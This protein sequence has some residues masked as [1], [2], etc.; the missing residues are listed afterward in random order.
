MLKWLSLLTGALLG[1]PASL[2]FAAACS[3][4]DLSSANY[5]NL[6]QGMTFSQASALLPCDST[7]LPDEVQSFGVTTQHY[8]WN[9]PNRSIG[10][11]FRLGTLFTKNRGGLASDVATYSS[12]DSTLTMPKV[13]VDGTTFTNARMHLPFGG[14]WS[15]LGASNGVAAPAD[16]A[17]SVFNAAA[18]TLMVPSVLIDG[19]SFS[20]V[21]LHLLSGSW[22]VLGVGSLTQPPLPEPPEAG[23]PSITLAL[24]DIASGQTVSTISSGSSARLTATIR[25]GNGAPIPGVVVSFATD[26]AYGAFSPATGTALSDANGLA[27]VILNASGATSGATTVTV[28]TQISGVTVTSSLN[29]AIGAANT[30]DTGSI[31]FVSVSPTSIGLRGTGGSGRQESATVIFRVVDNNNNPVGGKTVSFS[32]STTLGGLTLSAATAVSDP[33]SGQVFTNVIAGNMSTAVRVTATVDGFSTQSD[34][35]TISTGLPAQDSF[36]LSASTYNIEGWNYDGTQ[37]T[38]TARLADHFHNPVPDGTAVYFTSEG[39]SV[40]PSCTTVGGVCSV[41]FTSQALR[42]NNGRVTVTA[43]AI[44]EEAFTDLNSNGVADSTSEMID[45]N[46]TPTDMGE[47]FVDYNE[48]GVRDSNEPYFD[49]NGSGTYNSPDGKFNGLLCSAGTAIC[50]SQRS[51]DVRTSKVIVLSSSRANITING[52]ASIALP[53]CTAGGAGA[54]AT[55]TVTVVDMN[56]NAPPAGSTI[57]FTTTN[58]TIISANRI[59]ENSIGCRTAGYTGCPAAAGAPTFGDYLVTMQSDVTWST[60]TGACSVNQRSSGTFT[61]TVTTPNREVT[62]RS[63]TVTD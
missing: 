5:D 55:F 56:G 11:T 2:V 37:T 31:Q 26:A 60:T 16:S 45:A 21:W 33:A 25:D 4:A 62:E 20:N 38:L 27:S 63:A 32:L 9:S 13:N 3:D 52:G 28:G 46:G 39:G 15:V 7:R 51:I 47:A 1:L 6:R 29:Y 18:S 19:S 59:A 54:P 43:R 34:L 42:P 36:S 44:G 57:N 22:S 30:A 8:Q 17:T 48:N 10:L 23:T 58:G 14:S 53:A 50:S 40:A 24:I 35:L 49:F 12:Q 41:T 61:V